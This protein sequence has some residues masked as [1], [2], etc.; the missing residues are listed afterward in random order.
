[1][2][3]TTEEGKQYNITTNQPDLLTFIDKELKAQQES[4]EEH[5]RTLDTLRAQQMQVRCVLDRLE[6]ARQISLSIKAKLENPKVALTPPEKP[7]EPEE[8]KAD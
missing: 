1:M 7:A 5:L 3:E 2:P 6:G 8:A 4:K